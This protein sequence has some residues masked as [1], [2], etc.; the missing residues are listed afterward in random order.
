MLISRI[1]RG[2]VECFH[3]LDG[4]RQA[5][6][7]HR[8][9]YGSTRILAQLQSVEDITHHDYRRVCYEQPQIPQRMALLNHQEERAWLPIN[10]IE[11]VSK[12]NSINA[13]L[14]LSSRLRRY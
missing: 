3:S 10:S 14:N 5:M 13:K 8:E 9:K 4:N 11:V 6:L 2:Y 7:G 1:S 12:A